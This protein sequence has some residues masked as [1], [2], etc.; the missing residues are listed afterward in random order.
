MLIPPWGNPHG[1]TNYMTL[2]AKL[3]LI[4]S[5]AS[6]HKKHECAKMGGGL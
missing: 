4:F 2:I 3:G 5:K 1:G 6:H